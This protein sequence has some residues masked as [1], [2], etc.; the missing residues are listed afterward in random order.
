MDN[1]RCFTSWQWLWCNLVERL[2]TTNEIRGSNP[3][4][5]NF[6][7]LWTVLKRRN[8]EKEARNVPI[9]NRKHSTK[10]WCFVTNSKKCFRKKRTTLLMISQFVWIQY[11]LKTNFKPSWRYEDANQLQISF[12]LSKNN[13]WWLDKRV[14]LIASQIHRL[15]LLIESSHPTIISVLKKLTWIIGLGNCVCKLKR[16]KYAKAFGN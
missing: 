10:L 6:Y 2:L 12:L 14:I 7:L 13:L 5:G 15:F 1:Y 8:N 4:I 9:I 16:S 3:V 11:R